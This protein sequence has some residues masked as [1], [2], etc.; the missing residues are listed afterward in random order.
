MRLDCRLEINQTLIFFKT[1]NAPTDKTY[2]YDLI[3]ARVMSGP[4]LGAAR[5]SSSCGILNYEDQAY[6]VVAGGQGPDGPRDDT[7][8]LNL[9]NLNG[10]LKWEQGKY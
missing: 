8:L 5:V 7:E 10:A 9:A 3:E 1:G 2:F 6:V 4:T